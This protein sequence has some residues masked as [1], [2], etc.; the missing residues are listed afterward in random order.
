MNT[1]TVDARLL[2]DILKNSPTPMFAVDKN[3]NLI[4]WNNACEKLTGV[5]AEQ[6][7]GTNNQWAPFY[8]AKRPTMADLV[9]DGNTADIPKLYEHVSKNHPITES[10]FSAEGWYQN[11]GGLRRYMFFTAVPIKDDQG[12]TI[13]AVETLED[14]S[15]KKLQ[16]EELTRK[17][18]EISNLNKY[19]V[20]R[21][22]RMIELKKEIEKLQEK[23]E[24]M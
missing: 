1:E 17:L 5:K 24:G 10:L 14:I 13:A 18:E 7:L 19:M 9:I 15:S 12:Q 22:N 2:L 11:V 20:D 16:E 21:E 4:L 3:H 8:A 6:M 23:M